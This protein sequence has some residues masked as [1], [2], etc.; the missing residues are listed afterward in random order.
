MSSTQSALPLYFFFL[1]HIIQGSNPGVALPTFP[2]QLRQIKA[3]SPRHAHNITDLASL[4]LIW[5][6]CSERKWNTSE[7]GTGVRD[8]L[9]DTFIP[10]KTLT[11]KWGCWVKQWV[12]NDRL[13]LWEG[14]K[15]NPFIH[16][17]NTNGFPW[18]TVTVLVTGVWW[19]ASLRKQLS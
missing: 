2:Y 16:F 5:S 3:I 4:S 11:V 9:K 19:W 13:G 17:C 14:M 18:R 7:P 6:H 12:K 8:G 1:I 10:S 15:M